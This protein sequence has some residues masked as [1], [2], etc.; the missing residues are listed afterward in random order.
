[1][2]KPII[3]MVDVSLRYPRGGSRPALD[4]LYLHVD[5]DEV[6]GIVGESGSGKSTAAR[7]MIRMM[8]PDVAVTGQIIVDGTDVMTASSRELAQ[9]RSKT[10][11]M[12]HQDPRSALNPV[13]RVG[14]SA[15]ERLVSVLGV[16]RKQAW[17]LAAD[18]LRAMGLD[19][20]EGRMRQHP[21]ELSGGMLQR[22][23]ISA[24]LIAEPKVIIADEITSALDVTTQAEVLALLD[25][26]RRARS[27]AMV[28]IT[29]DLIL[30]SAICDRVY[31]LRQG[32]VVEECRG[33]DLFSSAT[34]PY[35]RALLDAAPRLLREPR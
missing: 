4:E 19:D 17:R 33:S 8:E 28:F 22:V 23:A 24:A 2:V 26:Q 11:G 14:D 27:A 29:H 20:P 1:M 34:H 16:D 12:I 31:V 9:I 3:E 7:A 35:S 10:V 15:T 6:V 21:H 25:D 13:R 32:S 30:A 5:P 18:A